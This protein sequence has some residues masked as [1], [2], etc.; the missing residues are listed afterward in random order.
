MTQSDAHAFERQEALRH[1]RFAFGLADDVL[2][3]PVNDSLLDRKVENVDVT[4]NARD[5]GL[6]DIVVTSHE[7]VRAES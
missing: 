6:V 4:C 2:F 5:D 7:R 1:M 3:A